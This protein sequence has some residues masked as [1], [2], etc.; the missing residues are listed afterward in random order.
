MRPRSISLPRDRHSRPKISSSVSP[1]ALSA[2]LLVILAAVATGSSQEQVDPRSGRLALGVTDLSVGAGSISLEVTRVYQPGGGLPGMLGDGWRLNWEDGLHGAPPDVVILGASGATVFGASDNGDELVSGSGDRLLYLDDGRIL[3]HTLD[4]ITTVFEQAEGFGRLVEVVHPNDNRVVLSQGDEGHLARVDGPFGSFLALTVGEDGLVTRIDSSVGSRVDYHYTGDRLV[5][6]WTDGMLAERY[7]YDGTGALVRIERPATGAVQLGYDVTGRV[8]SRRWDDGGQE[9]FHYDLEAHTTRLTHPTGGVTEYRWSEDGL[10]EEVT[11]PLGHTSITEYDSQIRPVAVTDPSGATTRYSYDSFGRLV[12]TM[13]REGHSTQ[14]EYRENSSLV[15]AIY[16]A[17]GQVEFF[18]YDDHGNL[19]AERV[20][21]QVVR[22]F[23]YEPKGLLQSVQGLGFPELRFAYYS[24]GLLHSQTDPLDRT[25]T[26]E[27]DDRGNLVLVTDPGGGQTRIGYDGRN[28]LIRE[29]DATGATTTYGY[30][31]Q[32]L[33]SG[34]T[35]PAGAITRFQYDLMGRLVAETDPVGRTTAYIYGPSDQLVTVTDPA[36]HTARLEYDAAGRLVRE[37]D[38]LGSETTYSYTTSDRIAGITLPSGGSWRFEYLPDGSMSVVDPA[39]RVADSRYDPDT[40]REIGSSTGE[41]EVWRDYDPLGRIV[42]T[43]GAEDDTIE[44]RYDE[45]GYL[46]RL[47]GPRGPVLTA[48]VDELGRTVL[49]RTGAGFE[50]RYRYD[51]SGNLVATEDNTGATTNMAYDE[52]GRRTSWTDAAGGITRYDYDPMGRPRRLTNPAG[53]AIRLEYNAAGDLT[54]AHGPTGATV[55]LEYDRGGGIS[56]LHSPDGG[57]S[58]IASDAKGNPI[59]VQGPVGGETHSAYDFAG[60]VTRATDADDHT[61]LFSYDAAGRLARRTQPDGKAVTYRYDP[62]GNPVEVDDGSFPIRYA[63][64][65]AGRLTRIEYPAIQ[66]SLGYSY[67]DDG[68]LTEFVDWQGRRY[69]YVFDSF[70]RLEAVILPGGGAFS[71]V[72]DNQDRLVGITYPNRTRKA[73]AYDLVG[74]VASISIT[75]PAIEKVVGWSYTYDAASNLVRVRDLRGRETTYSY[76]A[77]GRLTAEDGPAGTFEYSYSPGGNRLSFSNGDSSVEYRYNAADQLISAGGESFAYDGRGNLV[78]RRGPAGMTRYDFDVDNRLVRVVLPDGE[79]V[80]YGYAPTGERIWREDSAGRTW[81]LTDGRN[82]LAVLDEDLGETRR[83]W[84]GPG[85]D[86]PLVM[87]RDGEPLF[88]HTDKMGSVAALTSD[89][90]AIEA[91]CLTDAFGSVQASTGSAP[92]PFVFTARELDPATGLYD[93]R[94]RVYDPGLGRFLSPDPVLRSPLD[95]EGFSRYA[96]ARNTPTRYTDPTGLDIRIDAFKSDPFNK[97]IQRGPESDAHWHRRWQRG[98]ELRGPDPN[99]D[100]HA[101]GHT[102]D[103]GAWHPPRTPDFIKAAKPPRLQV[104]DD[105]WNRLCNQEIRNYGKKNPI[106]AR[107]MPERAKRFALRDLHMKIKE[108][109]AGAS[110]DTVFKYVKMRQRGMLKGPKDYPAHW[111]E[112]QIR[113]AMDQAARNKMRLGPPP[114]KRKPMWVVRKTPTRPHIDLDEFGQRPRIGRNTAVLDVEV[115]DTG[116]GVG[117]GSSSGSGSVVVQPSQPPST[118]S[119]GGG[120]ASPAVSWR[121]GYRPRAG[122][123]AATKGNWKPV[124]KGP[125]KI[126]P[127]TTSFV[128]TL[129][130]TAEMAARCH[131]EG[132]TYGECADRL[133]AGFMNQLK[134]SLEDMWVCI[135]TPGGAVVLPAI[136]LYRT[137]TG[138]ANKVFTDV[139]EST[140]SVQGYLDARD[141]ENRTLEDRKKWTDKNVDDEGKDRIKNLLGDEVKPRLDS[142][143]ERIISTAN[144]LEDA[145]SNL[146]RIAD[147]MNQSES[148]VKAALKEKPSTKDINQGVNACRELPQKEARLRAIQG[149]VKAQVDQVKGDV[150]AAWRLAEACRTKADA[151]KVRGLIQANDASLGKIEKA[152]AEAEKIGGQLDDDRIAINAAQTALGRARS[153]RDRLT[154]IAA[155]MPQIAATD[156]EVRRAEAAIDLFTEPSPSLENEIN[157]LV[158]AFGDPETL[159]PEMAGKFNEL[160]QLVRQKQ[161]LVNLCKPADF[162]PRHRAAGDRIVTAKLNAQAFLDQVGAEPLTGCSVEPARALA[163]EIQNI[164][165]GAAGSRQFNEEGKR[166]ARKCLSDHGLSMTDTGSGT[167]TGTSG[168]SGDGPPPLVEAS[169]GGSGGGGG[170]GGGTPP[171]VDASKPGETKTGDDPSKPP[172]GDPSKPDPAKP[173]DEELVYANVDIELAQDD[174][175]IYDILDNTKDA[176]IIIKTPNGDKQYLGPHAIKYLLDKGWIVRKE[177]VGMVATDRLKRFLGIGETPGSGG[178]KPGEAKRDSLGGMTFD[179]DLKEFKPDDPT[180]PEGKRKILHDLEWQCLLTP[181]FGTFWNCIWSCWSDECRNACERAFDQN[182]PQVCR[183]ADA[184]AAQLGEDQ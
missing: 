127:G 180:T 77:A 43:G 117:S 114:P 68:R 3:H 6:V 163:R 30:N 93:Y 12:E 158:R 17:L 176:E 11:D 86:N 153:A 8:I 151:V 129:I 162:P 89:A 137:V 50:V 87:W 9:T 37:V 161:S 111:S 19:L 167:G 1:T 57:I 91:W 125:T 113:T 179:Y 29:T 132:L 74:R 34:V 67:D 149:D 64:D 84:H 41:P 120:A 73:V 59:Q 23:T 46:I 141:N 2:A 81:F 105:R 107:D 55:S 184:L 27:Y 160:R 128:L 22:S 131:G 103:E 4:G 106:L 138:T 152:S 69:R 14:Y 62:S 112:K 26:F 134:G 21:D 150:D 60:R 98:W 168:G 164:V 51:E 85:L 61:F 99:Y 32:G 119:A 24:N 82:L 39:G 33:L 7:S 15:T 65:T 135:K 110:P 133:A 95:P 145:C 166:E 45:Q 100:R 88:F 42:R 159:S 16:H 157:N 31:E 142:M 169:G 130:V 183:D 92:N 170:G 5:E 97:E 40:R 52:V 49:A 90:G 53:R 156:A 20:D 165:E 121:R 171:L 72:H 144:Q 28:R 155:A 76:D 136:G 101:P 47:S 172:G 79:V 118:S 83:F 56:A 58:R 116:S 178:K 66:K 108:A 35:D 115:S 123:Q 177:R 96:Y 126:S 10:R 143:R 38:F 54:R 140:Y 44:F 71:F 109:P 78:E 63:Y 139:V 70:E 175:G 25:M 181:E 102:L 147:M 13:D 75:S 94:A 148:S 154:D 36:G 18:D 48:E 122:D 104:S 174:Y 173:G 80:R 146:I 182:E 124:T